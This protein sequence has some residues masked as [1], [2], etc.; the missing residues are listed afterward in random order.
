MQSLNLNLFAKAIF[1]ICILSS[2]RSNK[3]TKTKVKI[4]KGK[5]VCNF[6]VFGK[7]Q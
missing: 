5:K 2:S 3:V 7:N 4:I 1:L 6:A